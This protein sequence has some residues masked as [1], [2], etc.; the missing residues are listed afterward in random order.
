M[1]RVASMDIA[2]GIAILCV[3]LGHSADVGVPKDVIA[4]CFTF[5]MPLFFIVSGYFTRPDV[6]LDR[7][8]VKK[9]A[10]A[11]LYPYLV[12]GLIVVALILLKAL[13]FHHEAP[14]GEALSALVAVAYGAGAGTAALPA[15]VP[16]IGAIWFLLAMFWAKIFLA[17]AN[18]TPYTPWVVVGLFA[19]GYVSKVVWL[20]FSIQAGLC[21]VL[22]MYIGQKIREAGLLE[23]GA[24]HPVL[25]AAIGGMWLYTIVYGGGLCMVE[26]QYYDGIVVDVL[27]GVC[28]TLCVVRAS[29]FIEARVAPLGTALEKLG[30]VTLPVFCMHLVEMDTFPW[31][32][33]MAALGGL[34]VPGWAAGL[35][36]RCALITVLSLAVYL[37]PRVVSGAFYPSRAR[38]ER[39]F[40]KGRAARAA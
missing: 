40:G 14:L 29:Q 12:T 22:F 38:G 39:P 23:R 6:A 11:M 30:A 36:L 34:P 7:G 33:A 16:A 10:R 25:W 37:A 28:G 35:A 2:K 27:G 9:C 26:N 5:H 13:A 31:G 32:H 1:A 19:V 3:I 18:K 20:P 4:F 15:G 24:I 17:A 21:A 8:Y